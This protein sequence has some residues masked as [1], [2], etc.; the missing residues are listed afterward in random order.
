M[1]LPEDESQPLTSQPR[2]DR[3][4]SVK[5]RRD[6][7]RV[8]STLLEADHHLRLA[9]RHHGGRIPEVAEEMARLRNR[10]TIK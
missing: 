1:S 5:A 3:L 7:Q 10:E 4:G 6:E 9:D 2:D 8:V